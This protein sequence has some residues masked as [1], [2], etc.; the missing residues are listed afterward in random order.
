ME[1][2]SWR[3][4]LSKEAKSIY[5]H[6]T[7]TELLDISFV[8]SIKGISLTLFFVMLPTLVN[9]FVYRQI[10]S[11]WFCLINIPPLWLWIRFGKYFQPWIWRGMRE[12][13]CRTQWAKNQGYTSDNFTL[14]ADG[15]DANT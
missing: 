4:E 12:S 5:A 3:K 9:L 2:K 7:W 13:L 6:R 1:R 15:S 11:P 14:F 8:S 10:L